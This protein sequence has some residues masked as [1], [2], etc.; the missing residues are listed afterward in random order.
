M[1]PAAYQN[2]VT[3]RGFDYHY[4]FNPPTASKP[5]LVVFFVKHGYGVLAPDLLGYGGTD[6]P[7]ELA[8]YAKSLV[9]ADIID[10]GMKS[11]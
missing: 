11:S 9:L 3:P 7:S 2:I 8:A 1:D 6:K 5:T 4:F 10:I